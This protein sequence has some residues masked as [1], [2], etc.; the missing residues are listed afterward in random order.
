LPDSVFL[1]FAA[2]EK[3]L[4]LLCWRSFGMTKMLFPWILASGATLCKDCNRKTALLIYSC[5]SLMRDWI[6]RKQPCKLR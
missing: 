4:Q 1:F 3:I 6:G 5:A 2:V